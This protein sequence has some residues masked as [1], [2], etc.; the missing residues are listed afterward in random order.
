MIRV[1]IVG[2]SGY[3]ALESI[4]WLLRHPEVEITAATSRQGDGSSIANMHPEL[5]QRLRIGVEDLSAKQIAERLRRGV[6]LFTA[7][8]FRPSVHGVARQRL[9]SH[10]P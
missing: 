6:L 8:C 4:R 7:R 10:R 3:T 2:A 1:A 9:Q 5:E